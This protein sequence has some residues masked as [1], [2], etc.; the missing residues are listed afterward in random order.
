MILNPQFYTYTVMY[1][2]YVKFILFIRVMHCLSTYNVNLNVTL[3]YIIVRFRFEFS[4][5]KTE[6]WHQFYS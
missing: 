3:K 1:S 5:I 2:V 6:F 4:T